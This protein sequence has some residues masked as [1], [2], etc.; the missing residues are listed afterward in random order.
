VN[1]DILDAAKM[2]NERGIDFE[3]EG[4]LKNS[5]VIDQKYITD[6][7]GKNI[8]KLITKGKD[9][10]ITVKEQSM[11]MPD[12]RGMSL[13][14]CIKVIS[15]LGIDYKLSGSGKVVSQSIAPGESIGK[16]QIITINCAINEQ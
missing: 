11:K 2:L 8:I 7:N 4:A 15:S 1:F 12:V 6:E 9:E 10:N 16:N 3:V 14:S 13:R 5:I